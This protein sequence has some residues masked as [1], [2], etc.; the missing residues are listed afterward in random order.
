MGH[1]T[2]QVWCAT[3]AARRPGRAGRAAPGKGEGTNEASGSA[4]GLEWRG[5]GG[6]QAGHGGR[7]E[8]LGYLRRPPDPAA[9]LL[10]SVLPGVLPQLPSAVAALAHRG[11]LHRVAGGLRTL[12]PLRGNGRRACFGRV[13]G[14]TLL[15]L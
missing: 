12:H 9:P 13:L 15:E 2:H 6:D 5:R 10:L 11:H 1:K 3:A 4:G 7:E 8:L 14:P